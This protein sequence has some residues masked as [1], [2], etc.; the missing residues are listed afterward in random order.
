MVLMYELKINQA[1]NGYKNKWYTNFQQ[2]RYKIFN[3]LDRLHFPAT[4]ATQ[5]IYLSQ[6]LSF[7]LSD[8][9]DMMLKFLSVAMKYNSM[10]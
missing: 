1:V 4:K 7:S 10:T 5:I 8:K 3:E 6:I 2:P 9:T